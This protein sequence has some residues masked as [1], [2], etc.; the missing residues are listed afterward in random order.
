MYD[1]AAM[2]P[3]IAGGDAE[4]Y[5]AAH[6]FNGPAMDYRAIHNMVGFPDLAHTPQNTAMMRP[7]IWR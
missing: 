6:P 3:T 5:R 2:P 7:S 4:A 1:P